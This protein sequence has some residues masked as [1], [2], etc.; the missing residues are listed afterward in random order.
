MKNRYLALALGTGLAAGLVVAAVFAGGSVKSGPQPDD[1]VPGPFHPFNVNG[2]EAGKEACLFCRNGAH[3]VAM[4]FAREVSPELVR[5]LK[6]ID[7]A[8]A[9]HS[10]CHMG[11][12]TVFCSDAE[13]LVKQLEEVARAEHLDHLVLSTFAATGPAR[14]NVAPE[15]EVTVVLYSRFM[16]KANHAY[17]KG[18]LNDQEIEKIMA[19]LPK[20]LPQD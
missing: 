10:D 20:I 19:D 3:P 17:R 15:A 5:L 8:T 2:P 18:E 11:S 14:Y 9:A 1:K 16:V 4:I 7:A 12:F 6:K 13:G